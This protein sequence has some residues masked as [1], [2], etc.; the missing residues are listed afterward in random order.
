MEK[1][2]HKIGRPEKITPDILAKLETAYA[3]GANNREAALYAGVSE[4]CLY[5]YIAAHPDFK[6]RIE[7]LRR[8]PVLKAKSVIMD[9]L[10]SGDGVTARWLLERRASDEYTTRA[11]VAI[12]ADGVLTIEERQTALDDFLR[13]FEC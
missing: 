7:A 10:E 9:E 13:R 4:S 12:D 8:N 1:R 2:N 5:R 3:I 6:E 11:E